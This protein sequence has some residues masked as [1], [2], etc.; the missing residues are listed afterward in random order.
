MNK[1]ILPVE[2]L[3]QDLSATI[4]SVDRQKIDLLS[5]VSFAI[6]KERIKRNLSQK[7]FAEFM[8]VS[9]S[10]VSKW[11]NGDYNFTLET[12]VDIFFKLDKE[13][14]IDFEEKTNPYEKQTVTTILLNANIWSTTQSRSR[15]RNDNLLDEAV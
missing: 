3:L 1:E 15:H 13:C 2:E 12:L 7:E 6:S 9:Q 4:S 8:G 14:H 10:M 11:E 5:Q